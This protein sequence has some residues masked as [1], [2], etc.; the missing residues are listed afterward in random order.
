MYYIK[1]P[2]TSCLCRMMF[3]TGTNLLLL[4]LRTEGNAESRSEL[5][6]QCRMKV[7]VLA[8]ETNIEK[9]EATEKPQPRVPCANQLSLNM[10]DPT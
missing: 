8:K 6:H 10:T 9:L 2:K 7:K 1:R 3:V 5:T 4:N